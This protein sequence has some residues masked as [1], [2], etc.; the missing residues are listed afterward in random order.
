MSIIGEV[1]QIGSR[2]YY[3][4]PSTL[5]YGKSMSEMELL[6]A[7]HGGAISIR[8]Q[9]LGLRNQ[10]KT[11]STMTSGG[12][13]LGLI[14]TSEWQHV[15]AMGWTEDEILVVIFINGDIFTYNAYLDK[16][17]TIHTTW[18]GKQYKQ[19]QSQ[20]NNNLIAGSFD[21]LNEDETMNENYEADLLQLEEVKSG[22]VYEN[23]IVIMSTVG[24]VYVLG[25]LKGKETPTIRTIVDPHSNEYITAVIYENKEQWKN[26]RRRILQQQLQIFIGSTRGE[27]TIITLDPN[28]YDDDA[29]K[30]IVS[31]SNP[32][33][34]IRISVEIKKISISPDKC[35]AA[36]LFADGIIYSKYYT[37]SIV[38]ETGSEFPPDDICWC[39][40][41]TIALLYNSSQ[42]ARAAAIIS[43]KMQKRNTKQRQQTQQSQNTSNSNSFTSSS[44]SQTQS[45]SFQ[46]SPKLGFNYDSDNKKKKQKKKNK[47]KDIVNDQDD[48][49]EQEFDDQDD[50]DVMND[51]SSILVITTLKGEIQE[52]PFTNVLKIVPEIDGV[53]VYHENGLTFIGPLPNPLNQLYN[54]DGTASSVIL[55]A[56]ALQHQRTVEEKKQRYNNNIKKKIE[57]KQ[58][59]E[60]TQ[61]NDEDIQIE[62][63]FDE[64]GSEF[65]N[66]QIDLDPDISHHLRSIHGY[67]LIQASDICI[68]AST[69]IEEEEDD[70][71][72]QNDNEEQNQR[73]NEQLFDV[74]NI[75]SEKKKEQKLLLQAAS[76]AFQFIPRFLNI[77]L[78]DDFGGYSRFSEAI[79]KASMELNILNSLKYKDIGI[80]ITAVEYECFVQLILKFSFQ[81][82]KIDLILSLP[83][84]SEVVQFLIR[85]EQHQ[86][87]LILCIARGN[88][89]GVLSTLISIVQR[90]SN[91]MKE[92]FTSQSS[93]SPAPSPSILSYPSSPQILLSQLPNQFFQTLQIIKPFSKI[94]LIFL[95]LLKCVNIKNYSLLV[96][97]M[98]EKVEN[99]EDDQDTKNKNK[100][101]DGK[102]IELKKEE[103]KKEI[104]SQIVREKMEEKELKKKNEI[105]S[106]NNNKDIDDRG[107]QKRKSTLGF[108][109]SKGNTEK[110]AQVQQTFASLPP[111][112]VTQLQLD[113]AYYK[114]SEEAFFDSIEDIQQTVGEIGSFYT[115]TL[116][117][118]NEL[119]IYQLDLNYKYSP[120]SA[121]ITNPDEDGPFF[122]LSVSET[123]ALL[124]NFDEEEEANE[125]CE[126]FGEKSLYDALLI[127]KLI[128]NDQW[129]QLYKFIDSSGIKAELVVP[130]V[131]Q[132]GRTD[133]A[134][135]VAQMIKKKWNK[136]QVLVWIANGYSR[137]TQ[138]AVKVDVE[139]AAKDAISKLSK[140][141]KEK[142]VDFYAGTAE[143]FWISQNS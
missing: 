14:Q 58:N 49:D 38:L 64:N 44:N 7:S 104:K 11:L 46:L 59:K 126:K 103:M 31:F 108:E 9:A 124:V 87:S 61:M 106:I 76:L 132:T 94:Q 45:L 140:D 131:M 26:K 53:R 93:L 62:N 1:Y 105:D 57:R 100:E 122:G 110:E 99:Q 34:G 85:N 24:A 128:G 13:T 119:C 107:R 97:W 75:Q 95:N 77:R 133:R 10:Q 47:Y 35:N 32:T 113:C 66:E 20:N 74:L 118:F 8:P 141:E 79:R 56:I 135:P 143:G 5:N 40:P 52:F 90:L 37:P 28:M 72:E 39:S 70:E 21:L 82:C 6:A 112:V 121:R 22:C 116:D 120:L 89:E 92:T 18:R 123:I 63:N 23:G 67:K 4:H 17:R 84:T 137:V 98:K 134:L 142:L 139:D 80:Y 125:F 101:K 2:Y 129:E 60:R 69:L 127:Q 29:V 115:K 55:K 15:V 36:V 138:S 19:D 3:A 12:Q 30:Q 136:A 81:D 114:E 71:V 96:G 41:A 50:V 48:D 42:A 27:I 43:R 51:E 83:C 130:L 73:Q 86:L 54:S 109:F 25:K 88:R 111:T 65:D 91:I 102:L 117:Q 78:P 68:R 16:L 33:Q